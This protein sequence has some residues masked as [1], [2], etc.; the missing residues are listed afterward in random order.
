M[1]FISIIISVSLRIYNYS[2]NWASKYKHSKK[3]KK[4]I[5]LSNAEKLNSKQIKEIKRFYEN[6]NL[7]VD[8]KW[9][10]Y[11]YRGNGKFSA[12]YIN[13]D[14][15]YRKLEKKLNDFKFVEALTDKNLLSFIF[16]FANQ[17]NT[18]L[19]NINGFYI[20]DHNEFLSKAEV[21]DSLKINKFLIIKPTI[22]TGGGKN[23]KIFNPTEKHNLWEYLE[24]YNKNFIIQRIVEQHPVMAGLNKTS[25]NT[26]RIM[27]FLNGSS[28]EVLSIVV[29]MGKEG[30]F[31]DN[32]TTG[33]LSCGVNLEGNLNAVG[34]QN[35]T[36]HRFESNNNNIHFSTIK[37]PFMDKVLALINN[38]HMRVPYFKL[39]SWDIAI[40]KNENIVLVEYNVKGQDINLHQLNNGP[41]LNRLISLID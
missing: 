15:F 18:V 8:V 14:I 7:N 3:I 26:L 37:I 36:G 17:P 28:V 5:K 19:K 41:V 30:S 27:S 6:Y 16:P 31:T 9:H 25:L 22:D 24:S 33:G 2:S 32:S 39:I 40:D 35:I 21:E 11:Y 1:V 10:Q 38:L 34:F 20:N 23:V 13:E 12:S 4:L 29:R